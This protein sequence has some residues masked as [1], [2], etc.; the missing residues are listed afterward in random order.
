MRKKSFFR[1]TLKKIVF[2]THSP[3]KR[4]ISH[5]REAEIQKEKKEEKRGDDDGTTECE[6]QSKRRKVLSRETVA[7]KAHLPVNHI[8]IAYEQPSGFAWFRRQKPVSNVR[9]LN[10]M[11]PLSCEPVAAF[12]PNVNQQTTSNSSSQGLQQKKNEI[13]K[14]N[15]CENSTKVCLEN[16][17]VVIE[18]S[19]RIQKAQNNTSLQLPETAKRKTQRQKK[20]SKHDKNNPC[21]LYSVSIPPFPVPNIQFQVISGNTSAEALEKLNFFFFSSCKKKSFYLYRMITNNTHTHT[22]MHTKKLQTKL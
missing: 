19:R 4:V 1:F 11:Q 22:H 8:I 7:Q 21:P 3:R 20:A 16:N 14:D 12:Q 10:V 6:S 9:Q 2:D 18:E 15:S 17:A 13:T 5:F